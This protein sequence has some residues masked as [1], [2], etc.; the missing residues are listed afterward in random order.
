[1]RTLGNQ[2]LDRAGRRR[3]QQRR[4]VRARGDQRAVGRRR[5]RCAGPAASTGWCSCCRPT[6][7]RAGVDRRVPPAAADRSPASTS[8]ASSPRP[9]TSPAPISPTCATRRP[10]TRCTTRSR[11]GT[12]RM[13]EQRD[14]DTALREVRPSTGPWM[15]TAS[16][17]AMYANE[18]GTYDE[19]AAY[20]K[21]R[22]NPAVIAVEHQRR[23]AARRRPARDEPA[24][25]RARGADRRRRDRARQRHR[26]LPDRPMPQRHGQLR[27]HAAGRDRGDEAGPA[28]R[29]GPPA[30]GDRAT[31]ARPGPRCRAG[32]VDRR[33][34]RPVPLVHRTPTLAESLLSMPEPGKPQARVRGREDRADDSR[35]Q[36]SNTHI[37]HGPRAA[38]HRRAPGR[39]GLLR[40]RHRPRIRPTPP[41]TP[42]SRSVDLERG[43]I[44]SAGR[45]LRG[46]G[47]V[48]SRASPSTRTTSS[49]AAGRWT[50][51]VLDVGTLACYLAVRLASFAAAAG[52]RHR[53]TRRSGVVL[54]RLGDPAW[55]GC[56]TADAHARAADHVRA[57]LTGT[58]S[59]PTIAVGFVFRRGRRVAAIDSR[60][61]LRG[62]T[63]PASSR[64]CLLHRHDSGS[65]AGSSRDWRRSCCAAVTGG[66]VLG[67]DVPAIPAAAGASS[68]RQRA[69]SAVDRS[70]SRSSVSSTPQ[71]SRTRPSGD[72]IAPL[73]PPV[74]AR[75]Q[76][77]ER[78]R[79]A[80]QSR[81]ARRNRARARRDGSV[82]VTMPG[83]RRICAAATA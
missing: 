71:E 30:P 68:P 26:A 73:R 3:Q 47:G 58:P 43:R 76:A 51:P 44:V 64:C 7:A 25:R 65:A 34:S 46:G 80:D 13:I 18:G 16:N 10:N 38:E 4:P 33:R 2:L 75:V 19:L 27:R 14:F 22:K 21:K 82:N 61:R 36:M 15:A 59:R 78:R 37:T 50:D 60:R 29:M 56:R 52:R 8:S 74:G 6:A 45:G 69:T 66:T 28:Q 49:V 32:R 70:V 54:S 11:S 57:N 40:A 72:R 17:V 62:R 23:T 67:A 9:R 20:L 31:Q 55:C 77:A 63:R 81:D 48:E 79:G 35:R 1:M 12:V 41:A 42:T 5:R 53:R 39:P 24:G 83:I